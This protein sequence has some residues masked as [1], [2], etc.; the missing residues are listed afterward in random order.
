MEL[1]LQRIQICFINLSVFKNYLKKEAEK[2]KTKTNKTK[3]TK[4]KTK[5]KKMK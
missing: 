2:K 3:K 5:K 4:T 1:N